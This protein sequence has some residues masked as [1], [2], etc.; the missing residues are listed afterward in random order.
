VARIDVFQREERDVIA[1]FEHRSRRNT[2]SD[3]L[4]EH[5]GVRLGHDAMARF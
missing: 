1:V 2:A 5:T 3:D 4:A